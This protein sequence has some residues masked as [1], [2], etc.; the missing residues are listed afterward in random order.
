MAHF[1]ELFKQTLL[2]I[3]YLAEMSRSP[4]TNCTCDLVT[5]LVTL[6][7]VLS[8]SL[9]DWLMNHLVSKFKLVETSKLKHKMHIGHGCY[10]ELNYGRLLDRNR[11]FLISLSCCNTSSEHFHTS[12][13]YE[14]YVRRG[15]I[16]TQ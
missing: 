7:G 8:N 1:I 11:Q 5:W 2:L 3:V 16:R 4:V 14:C 15:Y 12:L 10:C 6:K 9:H 13:E